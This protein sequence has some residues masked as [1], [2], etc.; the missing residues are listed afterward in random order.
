MEFDLNKQSVRELNAALHEFNGSEEGAHVHNY[1]STWKA[2]YRSWI[3]C[4][5]KRH[6][7]RQCWLLLCRHE[8]ARQRHN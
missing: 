7:R 2:R 1:Q 3:R 8:Q 6:G 4:A 5:I